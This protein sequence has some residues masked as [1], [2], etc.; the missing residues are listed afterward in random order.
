MILTAQQQYRRTK[1]G[2]AASKRYRQSPKGKA[3]IQRAHK[4]YNHSL[5]AQVMCAYA[6]GKPVCMCPCGCRISK[7]KWLTIHHINH[8][9]AKHRK[10]IGISSGYAFYLWLKKNNYP[11]GFATVC[12]NCNCGCLK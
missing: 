1:S 7:L 10:R 11:P 2:I 3:T 12:Y 9:G 8:D 4:R 5:K 6:N